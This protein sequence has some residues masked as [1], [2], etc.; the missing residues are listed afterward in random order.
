[1]NDRPISLDRVREVIRQT[2]DFVAADETVTVT[3][4]TR[5]IAWL[6]DQLDQA[7]A[8]IES[9]RE[10]LQAVISN[11]RYVGTHVQA[12]AERALYSLD[13]EPDGADQ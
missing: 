2:M 9:T 5:V 8:H 10:H 3:D 4:E 13:G 11:P 6:V 1:M 7:N 12:E